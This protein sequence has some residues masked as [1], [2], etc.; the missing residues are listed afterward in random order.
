M[1]IAIPK[2]H[3]LQK[4][5]IRIERSQTAIDI[6]LRTG[7]MLCGILLEQNMWTL[8]R[9][10]YEHDEI[11]LLAYT[12]GEFE[13]FLKNKDSEAAVNPLWRWSI[14]SG[15]RVCVKTMDQT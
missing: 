7:W 12:L 6:N 13:E 3:A 9:R 14:Y 15:E 8:Q 10:Q 2:N 5:C 1:L 4:C 11:S